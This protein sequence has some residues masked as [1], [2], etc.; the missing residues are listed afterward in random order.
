MKNSVLCSQIPHLHQN[1]HKNVNGE[2][3]SLRRKKSSFWNQCVRI[4][5]SKSVILC[6]EKGVKKMLSLFCLLIF[7]SQFAFLFDWWRWLHFLLIFVCIWHLAVSTLVI[8][9]TGVDF[10][11]CTVG[12]PWNI[13]DLMVS[14][15]GRCRSGR[16]AGGWSAWLAM[17]DDNNY[18]HVYLFYYL[19]N[20][21][22]GC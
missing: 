10:T 21:I 3:L 5:F 1:S 7:R 12:E 2:W 22:I 15:G 11:N 13:F 6:K 18:E 17:I 8:W 16:R 20:I 19:G 14:R 4:S 9:L